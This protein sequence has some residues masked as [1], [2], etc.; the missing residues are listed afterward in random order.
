MVID[1]EQ[2]TSLATWS[3][4]TT[5]TIDKMGARRIF[6]RGIYS[7]PH[8]FYIW[9]KMVSLLIPQPEGLA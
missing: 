9:S 7:P 1:L 6:E 5:R 3:I 8:V 4:H 2:S